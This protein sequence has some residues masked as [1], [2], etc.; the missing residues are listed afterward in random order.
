MSGLVESLNPDGTTLFGTETNTNDITKV[1]SVEMA[2]ALIQYILP[3]ES[4]TAV[5]LFSQKLQGKRKAGQPLVVDES[6]A[7]AEE[8]SLTEEDEED[9]PAP[10][11]AAKRGQAAA[12]AS[13]RRTQGG[14]K[15]ASGS[16]AGIAIIGAVVA[17]LG[18]VGFFY[19]RSRRGGDSK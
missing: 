14:S 11:T 19:M 4:Y 1:M 2:K 10:K 17:V 9:E 8:E 16:G 6:E 12:A 13:A 15:P 3:L 5:K 7:E 18:A